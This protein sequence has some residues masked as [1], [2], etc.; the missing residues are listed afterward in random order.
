MLAQTSPSSPNNGPQTQPGGFTPDEQLLPAA[1]HGMFELLN[2]DSEGAARIFQDMRRDHPDSPLG[3]LLGADVLW[4]KIYLTTGNLVDPDVFDVVSKSTSPYDA[5]FMSMAE[6]AIRRADVRVRRNQDLARSLLDEGT[7]YGLLGRFYGLHDNDLPTARAGKKMRALLLR[8][9]QIDPSL[10][11]AD[12]GV[13]I[14]NY[15][16]DTLPE[17]VKLLRFV[18]G[19][20]GGS[21]ELGLQQLEAAA[22]KGDVV[23]G[24][25]EF[26]L[27][28]DFS[29]SSE[30]QYGKS[31][32]LFQQLAAQ[33]PGNPLWTLVEG[34]LQ[35]RLGHPQPGQELYRQAVERSAALT[36]EEGRAL[37]KQSQLALSRSGG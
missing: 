2:G 7:A 28:K 4:W 16:V 1:R 35:I 23:R 29:R 13:G 30:R 34:S 31:L 18:I 24:E 37:H 10:A 5:A 14:Y 19:L 33:Y 20:P 32:A 36:T 26:Y 17:I 21:R 27:A 8:A 15:F 3:Y 9:L 12:L 25:A 22:T 11:D 6:E